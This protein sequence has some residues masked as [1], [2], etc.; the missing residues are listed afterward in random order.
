MKPNRRTSSSSGP[1]APPRTHRSTDSTQTHAASTATLATS[2]MTMVPYPFL[3][4]GNVHENQVI[5]A[6]ISRI[7]SKLP[8]YS[9]IPYATLQCDEAMGRTVE[10]L[11]QLGRHRLDHVLWYLAELLE[12]ISKPIDGETPLEFAQSQLYVLKI[13]TA[14][15]TRQWQAHRA[16]LA[17]NAS[18]M[19]L[20]SEASRTAAP[21]SS[22][23]DPPPIEEPIAKYT[24][25]VI[26]IFFQQTFSAGGGPYHP[27]RAGLTHTGSFPD[28][29]SID[30]G[31]TVAP[32]R[33]ENASTSAIPR[34]NQQDT[35]EPSLPSWNAWSSLL[36][37]AAS[38]HWLMMKYASRILFHLSASNWDVVL[39]RIRNKIHFLASTSEDNP[40]MADLQLVE[41]SALDRQRLVQVLGELGSL[42]VGMKR[43]AQIAISSSVR[44]AIWNWIHVFPS[45]YIECFTVGRRLDSSAERCFDALLTSENI[46]NRTHWPTLTALFAMSPDRLKQVNLHN[47]AKTSKKSHFLEIIVK[48]LSSATKNADVSMICLIDLCRAAAHLPPELDAT[49]LRSLAPDLVDELRNRLFNPTPPIRLF[50]DHNDIIDVPLYGDALVVIYRFDHTR[51]L[52]SIFPACLAPERSDAVKATVVNACITLCIEASRFPWQPPLLSLYP[53]VS[54]PIRDIFRSITRESDKDGSESIKRPIARHYPG[55]RYTDRDQLMLA[56]MGL[57]RTHPPFFFDAS[58]QNDARYMQ[59]VRDLEHFFDYEHDIVVREAAA[60]TFSVSCDY[61]LS[62]KEGD[63]FYKEAR[64]HLIMTI[65]A[66]LSAIASAIIDAVEVRVDEKMSVNQIRD[67]L[68]VLLRLLENPKDRGIFRWEWLTPAIA[69]SE[70]AMLICLTSHQTEVTSSAASALRIIARI[71]KIYIAP[72]LKKQLTPEQLLKRTTAYESLV[73]PR[74]ITVGR[75]VQQKR[76]RK[77]L[78]AAACP[79]VIYMTVWDLC[80]HKWTRLNDYVSRSTSHEPYEDHFDR[81]HEELQS[82]WQNLT[83]FL[84]T[85]GGACVSSESPPS[86]TT[87]AGDDYLPKT[88][89]STESNLGAASSTHIEGFISSAVDLLVADSLFAREVVKEALGNEIHPR[90]YPSLV[91]SLQSV[92]KAVF[93]NEDASPRWEEYIIIFVEQCIAVF[94]LVIDRFENPAEISA[95]IETDIGKIM[96]HIAGFLHRSTSNPTAQRLKVRFCG[97]TD[98]LISKRVLLGF[99]TTQTI[100]NILLDTIVDW[101]FDDPSEDTLTGRDRSEFQRYQKDVDMACLKSA[102]GLVEGLQ[103]KQ[104]DG[105]SEDDDPHLHTRLFYRY[106]E[107][108]VKVLSRWQQSSETQESDN[109]SGLQR[110]AYTKDQADLRESVIQGLSRLLIANVHTGVS[111]CLR[112]VYDDDPRFR[113]IFMHVFTRVLNAKA[114][115]SPSAQ[116]VPANTRS[117]LCELVRSTDMLLAVAIC[118]TCPANETDEMIHVLLNVFDT[119]SSLV[120]LLKAIVDREIART[121]H[122]SE[123]FRSNTMGCRLLSVFAKQHGY[124]YLHTILPPLLAQMAHMPLD[125]SYEI[126][127]TR[128]R[129]P[130]E[131]TQNSANLQI[132]AKAFLEVICTSVGIVPPVF[133]EICNHIALSV[134]AMWPESKFS[135][136]GGFMFLRFINPAI[137]SP[138]SVDIDVPADHRSMRRGLLLVSKIIQGLGNNIKFGKEPFMTVLNDF[139]S[140]HIMTVA[141]FL[142]DV[143]VFSPSSESE[144]WLGSSYDETDQLILHRFL[145]A[146]ADKV[147]RELLSYNGPAAQRTD[148]NEDSAPEGKR[149]WDTLVSTLVDMGTPGETPRPKL[150]P[151]T[152]HALYLEF[153]QRNSHRNTDA[154]RNIL[155]EAPAPGDRRT[156]LIFTASR[157]NV[158]TV[159]LGLLTTHAFK[160]LAHAESREF[161][162]ILDCSAF[163]ATSEIPIQWFKHLLEHTPSD[164]QQ[165]L[166]TIYIVNPNK[167]AQKFLRKLCHVFSGLSVAKNIVAASSITELLE[168][169]HPSSA[170]SMSYALGLEREVKEAFA[171]V[172]RIERSRMRSPVSLFVGTSH[173]RVVTNKPQNIFQGLQCKLTEIIPFSEVDDVYNVSIGYDEHEFVIRRGRGET[174]FYFSSPQRENIVKALRIAK[175]RQKMEMNQASVERP[176]HFGDISAV[177]LNVGLLNV[178]HD[179]EYLRNAAYDLLRAVSNHIKFDSTPPIKGAYI[180][181]NYTAFAAHFSEKVAAHAPAL[182]L[183][184]LAEFFVGYDRA[185]TPQKTSCLH[186]M[187]SWLPNL[188]SFQDPTSDHYEHAGVKLRNTIRSIIDITIKDEDVYPVLQRAVWSEI[189]KLDIRVLNIV[190]DELFRAAIDGGMGSRRCEAV[191]DTLVVLSSINTRGRLLAKLRRA[192]CKTQVRPTRTLTENPVWNEVAA[193]TRLALTVLYN[194]RTPVQ[195]QMFAPEIFYLVAFLAATGPLAMRTCVYRTF[196]NFVQTLL[197]ARVDDPDAQE[198]LRLSLEHCGTNEVLQLFGIVRTDITSEYS[199]AES[200]SDQASVDVLEKIGQLLLEILDLGASTVGLANA[201]RARWMSLVTSTAF[202]LSPYIQ[203]RA[204]VVLGSLATADVDD[205]LFY[206]MLVAFKTALSLSNENDTVAV[207]SMLRCICRVVSGLPQNSRYLPQIPWVAIALIQSSSAALFSESARLLQ[208][209]L[210][211]LHAQ[212]YFHGRSLAEGL[213]EARQNMEEVADQLDH[214]LGIQFTHDFSFSLASV[215][216]KGVRHA[217]TKEAVSAALHS[218]LRISADTATQGPEAL[219]PFKPIPHEA[220]GFFLALLPLTPTATKYKILLNEA[221]AGAG[222]TRGMADVADEEESA[223]RIRFDVMAVPDTQASLLVTTFIISMLTSADSEFEREIL[224]DLLASASLAFPETIVKLYDAISDKINEIFSY[225]NNAPLVDSASQVFRTATSLPSVG[226]SMS[227]S[228]LTLVNALDRDRTA[229][230]GTA[231]FTPRSIPALEEIRMQ[232]LLSNHQFHLAHSS[233]ILTKWIPE[234]LTRMID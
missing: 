70:I 141:R 7:T 118:E 36:T 201:W 72:A 233:M 50:Y 130:D 86:I 32:S 63:P 211:T 185:R 120:A 142:N 83:L 204:F 143:A 183:D 23:C 191:A 80:Y 96:L 2:Q 135:S 134:H 49:P 210:E 85:L 117:K 5:Q 121:D 158:E 57:W 90:L 144:E 137:V 42:L 77:H 40:D 99:D 84:A 148:G 147:G 150:V 123:I 196:L 115:I 227:A 128:V 74:L 29:H 167:L 217:P 187:S 18:Q 65:P 170:A 25:S 193:L 169:L 122:E 129:H 68:K 101:A 6:L 103:L 212:R 161:D 214:F 149:V 73:D 153:M 24:L 37:T 133:R 89:K 175:G 60:K 94:K 15:M 182:T 33:V 173:V 151:S 56:I 126:D 177:L 200:T 3:G 27:K 46:G 38:V 154:V 71:E 98:T 209:S 10:S 222:W 165:R 93:E 52:Q 26:S 192:I 116:P 146:H 109:L 30:M 194:T 232:G 111:H 197:V 100:R 184:F 107:F 44:K 64:I 4:K 208:V 231:R 69:L 152:Q 198:R 221:G 216:F 66:S 195:T 48:A 124:N 188:S 206:Q 114:D 82:E 12:K 87:L 160:I 119:R 91:S 203:S 180:P 92:S 81:S 138:E 55:D 41:Y 166:S 51:A 76:I 171:D 97:L 105:S 9:G 21:T 156:A 224:Y 39:A 213:M 125:H 79:F 225:S 229:G 78:R 47:T 8:C 95:T 19:P 159:D 164:Q 110:K 131:L 31:P 88:L 34:S 11:V 218:L 16:L 223:P 20:R 163:S 220:L 22:W 178:G 75:L 113:T 106:Y 228:T 179:D 17:T 226:P 132:I 13:M 205:D 155:V 157:V 35:A 61:A 186:Y 181:T 168:S 174:A 1:F 162:L 127:P 67:V 43:E 199:L 28:F 172:T 45:E 230:S 53:V 145:T 62:L 176:A 234:L 14:A 190:L 139:L 104:I 136:V 108:F 54:C 140:A 215:L 112:R 207:V 202:Q 59:R 189:S 102:V 219:S 58:E